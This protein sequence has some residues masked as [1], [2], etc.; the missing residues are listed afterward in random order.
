MTTRASRNP[1]PARRRQALTLIETVV[2]LVIVGGMLVVT[3]GMLSSGVKARQGLNARR[4]GPALARLLLAEILTAAYEEPNDTPVFGCEAGETRATYDDVD[5]YNGLTESPPRRAD[6]TVRTDLAGWNWTV[7]VAYADPD[8]PAQD[9]TTDGGLKRIT[10][11]VTDPQGR[12]SVATALRGCG[13]IYEARPAV[14]TTYIT[15]VNLELQIGGDASQRLR[16]GAPV[17]N[18]VPQ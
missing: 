6:G 15:T 10:V 8:D 5:D 13:G 9:S 4:Q 17:L 16:A 2:S 18:R 3:M 12:R 11:A 14:Q 1:V 7:A